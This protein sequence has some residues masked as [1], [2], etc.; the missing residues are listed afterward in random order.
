MNYFF[1][2]VITTFNRRSL[3][4]TC[5]ESLAAQ[6]FDMSMCEVCIVDDGSSDGTAVLLDETV[7]PFECRIISIPNG[8]PSNARNVGARN[9]TGRFIVFL[10]DDVIVHDDWLRNAHRIL[11][12]DT[13]DVLEGRTIYQETKMDVR[14]FDNDE[15]LSF[16]PCNLFI[17]R[18]TF[19]KTGGYDLEFNSP[20]ENLYFR[21]DTELGFR[22]LEMKVRIKKSPEL[23]VEHPE[24]FSDIRRCLR[25]A[26]R[27]Q[28]DPLFYKKHPVRFRTAVDVKK[29]AG[30]TLHRPQHY[31]Y[32]GYVIVTFMF[33]LSLTGVIGYSPVLFLIPMILMASV[34][35]WKYQGREALKIYKFFDTLG[36]FILP[37][38]YLY[39]LIKGCIRYH[40]FGALV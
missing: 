28:F 35:R 9:V 20:K 34:F 11:Q 38:Y 12:L 37:F 15:Y 19:L 6:R 3:L 1:S 13:I 36:F 5:L 33:V 40:S 30:F 8:G 16:I 31:A 39:A 29:I 2:I 4:R 17:R 24:Q 23:I 25:H 18:E 10:E 7:L 32:L 26:L 27:Y 21:D 22:L 14:R